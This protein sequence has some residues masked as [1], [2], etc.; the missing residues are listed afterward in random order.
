VIGVYVAPPLGVELGVKGVV[1]G[2]PADLALTLIG[3]GLLFALAQVNGT[4]DVVAKLGVRLCRGRAA[5]LP[6]LFFSL[7]C[8]LSASG[9]GNIA[10][11]ALVAPAAMQTAH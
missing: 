1:A 2:F 10:A 5:L 3:V 7:T 11:V 4:L 8:L 9:A 6:I